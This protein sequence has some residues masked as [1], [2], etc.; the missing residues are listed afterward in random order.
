MAD[1]LLNHVQLMYRD[2]FP[3]NFER[4]LYAVVRV[5]RKS[6]ARS[7]TTV[8]PAT[9]RNRLKSLKTETA[10]HRYVL[11]DGPM[12]GAVGVL[13]CLSRVLVELHTPTLTPA[14]RDR[15]RLRIGS[16]YPLRDA[17]LLGLD[18]WLSDPPNEATVWPDGP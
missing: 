17:C 12:I 1:A 16:K 7:G 8:K 10:I 6:P 14:E 9:L 4:A 13:Q 3:K 5:W 18:L 11:T 15:L 2:L